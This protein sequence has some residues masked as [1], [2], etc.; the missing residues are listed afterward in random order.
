MCLKYFI[1]FI[2]TELSQVVV[3]YESSDDKEDF[4]SLRVTLS[5]ALPIGSG[6]SRLH[7][8]TL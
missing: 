2:I 5:T 1:K 7:A 8:A 3:C 4:K 6:L